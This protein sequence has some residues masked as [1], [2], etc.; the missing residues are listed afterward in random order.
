MYEV[1][2]NWQWAELYILTWGAWAFFFRQ[3]NSF[4][5][6]TSNVRNLIMIWFQ[7]SMAIK[8][9]MVKIC[10]W[11]GYFVEVKLESKCSIFAVTKSYLIVYKNKK[12]THN[13][14]TSAHT[15]C[16][17]LKSF[18]LIIHKVEWIKAIKRNWMTL[19]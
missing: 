15:L 5:L 16:C 1:T 6:D 12:P 3:F 8:S 11:S 13:A 7:S 19:L 9:L 2:D 10:I 4:P 17:L 14:H 18:V